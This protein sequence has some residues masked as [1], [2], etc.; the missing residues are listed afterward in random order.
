MALFSPEI[1][2]EVSSIIF[3]LAATLFAIFAVCLARFHFYLLASVINHVF[4]L[5]SS[6]Y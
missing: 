2:R 5:F 1:R 4:S 6:P 3:Q